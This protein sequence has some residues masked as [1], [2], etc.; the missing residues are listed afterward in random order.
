MVRAASPVTLEDGP[1]V[2]GS[3]VLVVEDGPT[4]T[5]GG[6]PFGA[7]TVAARQAGATEVVDPR[8]H[9]VGSIAETL[10]RYPHIGAVLPAMGYCD[11]AA[12]RARAR[13]STRSTATS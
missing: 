1:P 11:A 13:R 4:I 10:D 6:M 5:H 8:P 9:A 2:A 12:A 3:A 7:G